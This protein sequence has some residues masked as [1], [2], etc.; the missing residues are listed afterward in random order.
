MSA[1]SPDETEVLRLAE[2]FRA[3][4][5]PGRIRIICALLE[6]GELRVGDL[7]ARTSLSETACSHSLRLLRNERVVRYRKDGRSVL[8]ALDD[9]H[10]RTLLDV[11]RDHV[12]HADG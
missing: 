10:V 9:D 2:T 12:R 5:E 11:A 7:A 8:Y 3:L 1:S 6:A 4:A